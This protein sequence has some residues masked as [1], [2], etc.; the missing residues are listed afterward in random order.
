MSNNPTVAQSDQQTLLL[1]RRYAA[2]DFH[3]FVDAHRPHLT[4]WADEMLFQA[5][6]HSVSPLAVLALVEE[7]LRSM[8]DKSSET[9]DRKIE[10]L[11]AN[12][13]SQ[14]SKPAKHHESQKRSMENDLPE[15]TKHASNLAKLAGLSLQPLPKAGPRPL[16]D[17][18]F[19]YNQDWEFYGTHTYTGADDGNPMSSID[20]SQD[21]RQ[22]WDTDTSGSRILAAHDGIAQ[23]YGR[24]IMRVSHPSG[25]STQYYHLEDIVVETGQSVK[26]GQDLAKYADDRITA[27]CQGG[28]SR[29]PHVHFSLIKDGSFIGIDGLLLGEHRIKSG[30]FSYDNDPRFSWIDRGDQRLFALEGALTHSAAFNTQVD[31][32]FDGLWFPPDLPGHGLSL[33]VRDG[34]DTVSTDVALV[35]YTYDDA[36]QAN[37]YAGSVNV[38]SWDLASTLS[39]PLFQSAGGGFSTLRA[40]DFDSETDFSPAGTLNLTFQDCANGTVTFQLTERSA[41]SPVEQTLSITRLLGEGCISIR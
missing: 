28:L 32:T 33:M 16:M 15:L 21:W 34:E 11:A 30:R 14:L 22:P 7:S 20:F 13:A 23:V 27:V 29:A 18:P 35:L 12:L 40:V 9:V 5:G 24:C 39:V 1:D 37:F 4:P 41:G 19:A 6:F 36:G 10:N 31:L 17:L 26:K 25:W 38:E 2:L 8:T 3:A